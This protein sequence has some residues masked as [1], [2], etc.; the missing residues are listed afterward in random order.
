VKSLR[1]D[2]LAHVGGAFDIIGDV[3]GCA[4]ELEILLDKLGWRI[5]TGSNAGVHGPDGRRLFFVGDLVDRGPRIADSLRLVMS[6]VESGRGHCVIGNH[7]NK[8]LRWLEGANVTMTHGLD[9]TVGEM[10]RETPQFQAHVRAFLSALPIY[11]ILDE[12]RLVVSHAGIKEHMIGHTGG[13]IREFCLYGD[14]DGVDAR[15]LPIRYDWAQHYRGKPFVAYGHTPRRD[16]PIVN[17]TLC[18]DTGCVFGGALSALR[19][20]ER[21]IVSVPALRT[22]YAI[23]RDLV[24]PPPRPG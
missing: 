8:F 20:P 13:A 5:N 19:W 9:L 3:H 2:D 1:W 4:D 14:T 17:N 6:A 18:I 11:T 12:H 24:P 22:Y 16:T 10:R 21:E 7:D 15:G 23:K